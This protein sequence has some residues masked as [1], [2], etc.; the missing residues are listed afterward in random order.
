[1]I[2]DNESQLVETAIRNNAYFEEQGYTLLSLAEPS[3]GKS[4]ASLKCHNRTLRNSRKRQFYYYYY[5]ALAE[6]KLKLPKAPYL[7]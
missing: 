2:W 3:R 5:A 1:V 4:Q 6:S 7:I